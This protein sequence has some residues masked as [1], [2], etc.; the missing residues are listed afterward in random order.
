[1]TELPITPEFERRVVAS[2]RRGG[3]LRSRSLLALAAA[4]A[5]AAGFALGVLYDPAPAGRGEEYILFLYNTPESAVAPGT[6]NQRI[7]EY[8]NW[9]RDLHERGLMREG[10]RLLPDQRSRISGY[11]RITARD[12]AEA[13]AVARTCP[14]LRHGG[15]VELRQIAR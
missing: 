9:A 12:R 10:E 4:A 11:F 14:H 15:L 6:L 8:G 3:L 2:L 5:L 1:M 13:E 7:R